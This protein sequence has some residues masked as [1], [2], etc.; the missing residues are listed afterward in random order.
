MDRF[1]GSY[2]SD[3]VFLNS[4]PSAVPT[5]SLALEKHDKWQRS[6]DLKRFETVGSFYLEQ[7]SDCKRNDA[8]NSTSEEPIFVVELNLAL[9]EFPVLLCITLIF[10]PVCLDFR[11]S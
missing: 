9:V 5:F 10:S 1:L 2:F 3:L 4:D 7:G 6:S 11:P 8:L